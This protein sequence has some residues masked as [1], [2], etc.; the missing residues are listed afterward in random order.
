MRLYDHPPHPEVRQAPPPHLKG[1][2]AGAAAS[3]TGAAEARLLNRV[4]PGGRPRRAAAFLSCC[5]NLRSPPRPRSLIR[6]SRGVKS[7]VIGRFPCGGMAPAGP[8]AN[9][10]DPEKSGVSNRCKGHRKIVVQTRCKAGP[11][12]TS[13][14][15]PYRVRS[16]ERCIRLHRFALLSRLPVNG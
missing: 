7:S 1:P 4:F 12:A 8:A 6:P 10:S 13:F 5:A 15:L 9:T 16:S 3:E 14:N 11:G 2:G